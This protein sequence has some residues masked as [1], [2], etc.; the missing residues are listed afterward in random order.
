MRIRLKEDIRRHAGKRSIVADRA[1]GSVSEMRDETLQALREGQR[2][3]SINRELDAE[4]TAH[5]II[6]RKPRRRLPL[7]RRPRGA[8]PPTHRTM[9]RSD[10]PRVSARGPA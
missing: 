8:L 4:A 5:T 7:D 6:I 9:A 10:C 2:D 3:G 1:A